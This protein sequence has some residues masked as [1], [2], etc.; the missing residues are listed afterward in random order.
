MDCSP[1]GR[2]VH[3]ILQARTLEWVAVPSSRGS[4]RPRDRNCISCVSCTGRRVLYHWA[5]W[6]PL[7]S[8]ASPFAFLHFQNV[9]RLLYGLSLDFYVVICRR[10]RVLISS[11]PDLIS[12]CISLTA[13]TFELL[14][15]NLLTKCAGKLTVKKKKKAL[16][17]RWFLCCKN[18]TMINFRLL[19]WCL[20]IRSRE[21]AGMHW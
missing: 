14:F 3:G 1:P 18:S 12:L 5:T 21:S 16:I 6:S 8:L 9:Y 2:S 11:H 17:C 4:S 15:V 10:N 19:R 13:G 7:R 20:W